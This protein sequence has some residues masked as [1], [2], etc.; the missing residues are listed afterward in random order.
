MPLKM[1]HPC[2]KQ[3]CPNLTREKYCEAYAHL[4]EAEARERNNR[5]NAHARDPEAQAFYESPAWRALRKRK[6]A[7][8]P[9]CE[10]CYAEGRMTAAVIVDHIVEIKDGGQ[11]LAME[12]L[13]S[14][15]KACH[16]KKT[17]QERAKR[18]GGF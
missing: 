1:L 5:Y 10:I 8:M 9:L 3:G 6:L 17:A 12:N 4:A 11:P 16:N 14:V 13:Q 2:H 7:A 18:K 15:C